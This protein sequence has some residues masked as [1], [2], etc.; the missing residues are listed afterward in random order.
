MTHHL[1]PSSAYWLDVSPENIPSSR[2]FAREITA[3]AAIQ[4]NMHLG[5]KEGNFFTKKFQHS[6]TCFYKLLFNTTIII[7]KSNEKKE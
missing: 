6:S 5:I 1:G 7:N 2:K 4:Q 3:A